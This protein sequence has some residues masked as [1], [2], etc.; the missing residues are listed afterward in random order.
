MMFTPMLTVCQCLNNVGWI[1][2]I[3]ACC[4][5]E[6]RTTQ[7]GTIII[8]SKATKN[9]IASRFAIE[10]MLV[11]TIKKLGKDETRKSIRYLYA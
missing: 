8:I 5:P 11:S 4:I 2:F 9:I 6:A 3:D 10:V 1:I 7:Q